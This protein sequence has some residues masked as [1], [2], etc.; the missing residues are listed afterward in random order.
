MDTRTS[1]QPSDTGPQTSTGSPATDG[2]LRKCLWRSCQRKPWEK[3]NIDCCHRCI[4]YV[5]RCVLYAFSFT[6]A[7]FLAAA[8]CLYLFEQDLWKS[9]WEWFEGKGW[10]PAGCLYISYAVFFLTALMH[11]WGRYGKAQFMARVQDRGYVKHLVD[12]GEG[13][14]AYLRGKLSRT[15]ENCSK[16][17]AEREEEK[18]RNEV[19]RERLPGVIGQLR[20]KLNDDKP[21]VEYDLLALKILLVDC[22]NNYAVAAQA[23]AYLTDLKDYADEEAHTQTV[24]EYSDIRHRVESAEKDIQAQRY[25][26]DHHH[27]DKPE[28][29]TDNSGKNRKISV[30]ELREIVKEELLPKLTENEKLWSEGSAIVKILR[31][32][33][34]AAI[35]LLLAAGLVP[36][37]M[38]EASEL[39]GIH[40]A[41]LGVSGALVAV[42]RALGETKRLVVGNE[43]GVKEVQRAWWGAGLGLVAGL[44][45]YM[46][47]KSGFVGCFLFGDSCSPSKYHI[48]ERQIYLH[49]LL[50]F[51]AGY[52][53]ERVIDRVRAAAGS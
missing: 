49:M 1:Q 29:N 36:M 13:A 33:C 34:L 22:A 2:G 12:S 10:S 26:D 27:D 46:L 53:F 17:D 48:D 4:V 28:S 15:E 24:E 35:P 31:G 52:A 39:R 21:I 19:S 16:G 47:L 18:L 37:Y 7:I 3:S 23:H 38:G 8:C 32:A 30:K 9:L 50:A 20:K 44:L 43:Q 25:Y 42:L 5:T 6:L 11:F 14:Q 41:I 45:T 51:L 40:W